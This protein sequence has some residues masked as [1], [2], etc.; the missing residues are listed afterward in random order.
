MVF[1]ECLW[2]ESF[3]LLKMYIVMFSFLLSVMCGGG[4]VTEA[5]TV[6]LPHPKMGRVTFYL[7]LVVAPR[8]YNE[9][10]LPSPGKGSSPR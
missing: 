4:A 8:R 7:R 10:A 5:V 9:K 3:C 2:T 6:N 1:V